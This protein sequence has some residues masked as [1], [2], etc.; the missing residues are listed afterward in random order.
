[1][2]FASHGCAPVAVMQLKCS[3]CYHVVAYDGC[4]DGILNVNNCDLFTHELLRRCVMLISVYFT[5]FS[6]IQ[7]CFVP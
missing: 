1:M 5:F 7:T 2:V 3:A 4:T 6:S